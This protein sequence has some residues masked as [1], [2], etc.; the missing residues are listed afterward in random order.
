MV[1]LWMMGCISNQGFQFHYEENASRMCREP[2][3]NSATT[4]LWSFNVIQDSSRFKILPLSEIKSSHLP[5]SHPKKEKI[6]FQPSIFRCEMVRTVSFRDGKWSP[7]SQKWFFPSPWCKAGSPIASSSRCQCVSGSPG[8]WSWKLGGKES[9]STLGD[10]SKKHVIIGDSNWLWLYSPGWCLWFSME[11]LV[12][13]PQASLA[14]PRSMRTQRSSV[15]ARR[16]AWKD[17]C[18]GSKL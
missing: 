15:P 9:I 3:K 14:K 4:P 7:N 12:V 5:E 18:P 8:S 16:A 10:I 17:S 2:C 6:V 11:I 1:E 13:V